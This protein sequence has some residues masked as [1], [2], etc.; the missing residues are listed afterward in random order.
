MTL[1][2]RAAI[3]SS[4]KFSPALLFAAGEVGAWYDPSDLTTMFQDSAGTTPVTAVEQPVGLILDKSKG[5]AGAQ[6]IGDPSFDVGVSGWGAQFPGADVTAA[7]NSG[8]KSITVT[9]GAGGILGRPTYPVSVAAGTWYKLTITTNAA[10]VTNGAAFAVTDAAN[11]ATIFSGSVLAPQTV[12][13]TSKSFYALATSTATAYIAL[14]C[15]TSVSADFLS[16]EFAAVAGNH[17][18]QAT[19]GSR[20]MLSAR[21]NLLTR[22]EEFDNAAWV[23]FSTTIL[24]NQGTDPLGG[25]TADKFP[26]GT[27]TSITQ[28]NIATTSGVNYTFSV[29]IKGVSAGGTVGLYF[30]NPQT[31]PTNGM[32]A[33]FTTSWQKFTLTGNATS[34]TTYVNI[35]TWDVLNNGPTQDILIW[36][37]DLRVANEA[38][39]LPPYQRVVTGTTNDYDT[40]GFPLYLKFDGTDDGLAT[41]SIDFSGTDKVTMFAGVRKLSDASYGVIGGLN[42]TLTG[43]FELGV[44]GSAQPNYISGLT[45]SLGTT[46][47]F[48]QTF[49]APHTGVLSTVFDIAGAVQASE[50]F[51][52]VNGSIPTLVGSGVAAAGTGNFALLPITLGMRSGGTFPFSGRLYGLIVRGAATDPLNISK[53]EAW[54]NANTLAY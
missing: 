33:T 46:S 54:M 20:P 18:S 6:Q 19:S 25:N 29:W 14:W 12:G 15:N 49:A 27:G 7:W 34:G 50:I 32:T 38:A 45:A 23:K 5:G 36:G 9:R 16:V 44:A 35:G 2:L 3:L 47:F 4:V 30:S 53:A 8:L 39:N 11:A 21:Y 41:A 26:A 42:N 51:P 10:G 40:T 17:A 43:S 37:A 13:T 24:A 28:Q 31:V 52:R 1:P 22:T 48:C